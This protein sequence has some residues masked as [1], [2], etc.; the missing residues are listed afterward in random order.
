MWSVFTV[1]LFAGAL[2]SL[3]LPPHRARALPVG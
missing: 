3:G 2:L 1:L